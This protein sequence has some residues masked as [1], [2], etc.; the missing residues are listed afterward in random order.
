MK[1]YEERSRC[2][3]PKCGTASSDM[4]TVLDLGTVPLAG[5]FPNEDEKDRESG[6][7]L[8]LKFCP[9][10]YLVQT[11]SVIDPDVLFKDYRYLSSVGLS[12][13]FEELAEYIDKEWGLTLP[14]GADWFC[15]GTGKKRSRGKK[16]LEFGCN[17]GVLLEPLAKRGAD[18]IGVDPAENIVAVAREKGLMVINEYFNS[19]NF[20][21][22]ESESIYDFVLANNTFAHITDIEDVI[23]TIRHILKPNAKF[24]FE[25]HYL[26]NL[27]EERQWDNIYHEHIYYYSISALRNLFAQKD[28][29][30]IEFQEIPIHA[31]SIRVVVENGCVYPSEEVIK[32]T[33]EEKETLANIDFFKEY[34]ESVENHINLIKEKVESLTSM[35]NKIAGYGASGR[36]NM[37]CN[38]VGL[39]ENE[40]S[41]I[42]DESPERCNRYIANK[43]IPI[44]SKDVLD[45]DDVD[46]IL[47]FAW[48]YSK[49]IMEKTKHKNCKYLV[50]FPEPQLVESYEELKG[51][52]SI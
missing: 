13:H 51:F 14:D 5:F 19:N 8:K 22:P 6:F 49:M 10:C 23:D 15:D 40:V 52:E 4:H 9:K 3:C 17:D 7:P 28:M 42:V 27:I 45:N 21:T 35:G 1:T 48:N 26:R 16:V 37:F 47:I 46:I 30:V 18:V 50:A 34:S 38:I 25:V 29:T 33:E 43:K 36:A 39:T 11:D 2:A 12:S 24:I 44:V 41:Y 32:R 31:G 20:I